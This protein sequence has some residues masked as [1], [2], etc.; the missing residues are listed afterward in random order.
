MPGKKIT[1]EQQRLD[2]N[3]LKEVPLE[4][5]GPYLSERQWATV[6][7]D[8]SENGDAWN[9][10]PHDHARSRVYRWG[11]DGLGGISDYFQNLCFAVALWNHKDPIL[12]ERLFG[13]TNHEGNH[14]EDVKELYYYLDN[15]PSHYYMK[16]LYKYPQGAYPYEDIIEKNSSRS[17]HEPEYEILDTGIFNDN[18]YFDV[19]IEY[20]KE[21]SEDIFIKIEIVNRGEDAAPVTVL[22]TLWFYNRWQYGGLKERPVIELTGKQSVKTTHEKLG[23]YYL[24]FQPPHD[25]LFTENETNNEKLFGKLNKTAFVKDAF[26]EA[27]I[28]GDNIQALRDKKS[29]TK[30]SPVYH[31]TIKGK[32]SETIFL[33]LS[34]KSTPLPF[35][36]G[37]EK[38]FTLRKNEA[39]EFYNNICSQNL[40]PEI[41]NIQRQAFAGLLWS[42]QYYH[43]DL[44]RWLNTS[45]GITPVTQSRQE[46]RNS[47]WKYLKN[48]DIIIMPDTWEY[49]WYAA[50][51]TAFH[52]IAMS[53]IDAAFAKNQLIMLM[54]EWYMN[55]EGQ[56]PAY[57]WNFSDVNPPVHAFAALQVY[58]REKEI[59]GKG[60]MK[61]LKQIFQKL[62]I[63]FTW[64]TNRKDKNGNNIFE[65]G[66][67]GLDNI[68]VFNRSSVLPGGDVLEQADGTSWMGMYALSMMDI[69]LEIA[70]CDDAFEDACTKF[71]E[72]FVLIA[73]ALNELGLWNEEDNFFYDVLS[74]HNSYGI[75]L[76]VRS[77]VG[78]IPLFAV[79]V[80]SAEQ[81]DKLNDFKKRMDWFISYRRANNKY[82]PNV[83]KS[84][85]E[86]ILLSMVN[87]ERLLKVLNKLLDESEFL[88]KGGIRALSKY[89]QQNPYTV[90]IDGTTFTVEY[91]PGDSTSRLFGG[92][93]NWRGPVWMPVNYLIIKAIQRLGDYYE[94]TLKVECPTGSGTYLNLHDVAILLINRVIDIFRKDESGSKPLY[95][96]YN[97]FY[98][99][100]ENKDLLLFHE[101]F[102]GDN[103]RG[104][105]ASHQTG[106]TALVTDLI[107]IVE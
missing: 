29:G 73:E 80:I 85:K 98:E 57:E 62:I 45:D 101:Y 42:K 55:P 59:Q 21:N 38:I 87:K 61:F 6:R 65:G 52:C 47:N 90:K 92:N 11:E 24:Y 69:A 95:D 23:N 46:G 81:I 3:A 26:H 99:K 51:D 17:P 54:R 79:S 36:E 32:A 25:V 34:N 84:E 27:I 94:D 97:W 63:N 12:K 106:W 86:A 102:H 18:K 13:L 58:R 40:S 100:P 103:A 43:Y 33:R 104:L 60:D 15:L 28:K 105:G 41:A 30:F 16:Y 50:W 1:A 9:Y 91:D 67:L 22:P 20:A 14:G 48:Q 53:I 66:F 56:L 31:F 93:S 88:S 37:F 77:I 71:Y 64:W 44:E 89:Y 8:Y 83:Y 74:C 72:H 35:Q 49:P 82:L 2:E 76:K 10:F 19:F 4:K 78:V 107:R 68:G 75:P 96:S 7:E 39:D 70:V 5:W